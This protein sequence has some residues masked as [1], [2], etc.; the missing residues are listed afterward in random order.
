MPP[1]SAVG[2]CVA[3]LPDLHL[4]PLLG[5]L[6]TAGDVVIP[7]VWAEPHNQRFI[8]PL[9]NTK[10]FYCERPAWPFPA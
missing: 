8:R 4:H 7:A 1:S 9:L 6:L 5:A 3:C 10:Y 2:P